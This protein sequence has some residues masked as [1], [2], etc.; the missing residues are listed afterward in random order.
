[1]RNPDPRPTPIRSG[2]FATALFVLSTLVY[3]ALP[4]RADETSAAALLAPFKRDLQQALKSGLAKGPV[5]A[6]DTC[7]MEAPKIAEARGHAGLRVGRT[8]HRL[9]N[10]ANASPSWV[11]PVLAAYLENTTDR[12]PREIKLPGGRKGYVEPIL[13]QALC[14]TCHGS[15]LAPEVS[16][17]LA[18]RY[19]EDHATGFAEGDLRGVFWIELP[20]QDQ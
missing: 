19:P 2:S 6:I 13:T 3:P 18:E 10:P 20:A 15:S 1:M 17:R 5:E 12:E 8:S 7:R 11:E 16:E 4:A 9:R 14:L